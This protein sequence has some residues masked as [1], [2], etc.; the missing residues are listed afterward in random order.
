MRKILFGLVAAS[1][2]LPSAALAEWRRIGT[3]NDGRI[4]ISYDPASVRLVR[5]EIRVWVSLDHRRN[6]AVRERE[7]RH[8]WSYN[9]EEHTGKLI[10]Y[11]LYD[12]SG[13]V[14]GSE[15]NNYAQA[16]PVPP[17]TMN[18]AVFD[19]VCGAGAALQAPR[20]RLMPLPRQD[21]RAQS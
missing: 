17:D 19:I 3:T 18:S 5:G 15:T 2:S 13:R 12:A 6:P 14:I 21:R 4:D 20:A 10:S 9:C 8:L 1:L 11:V 16:Q 7:A